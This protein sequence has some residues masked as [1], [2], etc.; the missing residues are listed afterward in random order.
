MASAG[1]AILLLA[2]SGCASPAWFDHIDA[3]AYASNRD[4]SGAEQQIGVEADFYFRP[5][6]GKAVVAPRK[7]LRADSPAAPACTPP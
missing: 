4:S 7:A 3:K 6:D 2:L 1:G 5:R